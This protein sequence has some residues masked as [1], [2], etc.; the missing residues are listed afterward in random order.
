MRAGGSRD[1]EVK[2]L[3]LKNGPL[4]TLILAVNHYTQ[5]HFLNFLLLVCGESGEHISD[6]QC[7]GAVA[8][9]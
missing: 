6:G 9:W 2:P 8:M 1:G 5:F 4:D 7:S 3:A